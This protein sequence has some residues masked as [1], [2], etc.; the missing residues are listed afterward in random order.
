MIN[1]TLK[2][3]FLHDFWIPQVGLEDSILELGCNCGA[4]LMGLYKEGYHNLSGIEINENA[5]KELKHSFPE[6]AKAARVSLGSVEELLPKIASNSVDAIFTMAVLM[7]IHPTS[8]FIFSEMVRITRKYIII[9]EEETANCG[10]IY[11]RNYRRVLE[12][13]DCAQ[14][15]SVMITQRSFP[16]VSRNY[17]GY[18][19]R[20]FAVSKKT[21]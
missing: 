5:I 18:T 17:D 3:R 9:V 11:I 14:L 20:M 12:T 2:F 15:K 19:A 13:I 4:N 1:Y 7:H 10:Y 21:Y 16:K 8:N 6:L